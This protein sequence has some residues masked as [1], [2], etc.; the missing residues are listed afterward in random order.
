[1][2]ALY[3]PLAKHS[4]KKQNKSLKRSKLQLKEQNFPL[5]LNSTS[6]FLRLKDRK[7]CIKFIFERE[8]QQMGT[9]SLKASHFCGGVY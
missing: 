8:M 9:A 1:M 5:P 3:L 7:Q 2:S 6:P 4:R